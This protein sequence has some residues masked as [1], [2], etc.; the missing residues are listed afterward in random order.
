MIPRLKQ[1]KR[2]S[3]HLGQQVRGLSCYISQDQRGLPVQIRVLLAAGGGR[4]GERE[5]GQGRARE[6]GRERER[7][8]RREGERGGERERGGGRERVREREGE[9]EREIGEGERE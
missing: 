5:R 6:T 8:R 3:G 9:S 7:E 2:R 4:E 1:K